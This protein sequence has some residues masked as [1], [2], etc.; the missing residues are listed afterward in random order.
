MLISMLITFFKLIEILTFPTL[1]THKDFDYI[2]NYFN[3]LIIIFTC[4]KTFP[5]SSFSSC[6]VLGHNDPL[7][8]HHQRMRS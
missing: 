6:L 3:Q 2:F 4:L 5:Y 1:N 7:S 8:K